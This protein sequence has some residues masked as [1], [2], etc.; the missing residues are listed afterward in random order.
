MRTGLSRHASESLSV[1]MN[2]AGKGFARARDRAAFFPRKPPLHA[3]ETGNAAP[4][5][6]NVAE[7]RGFFERPQE[8][9]F[10]QDYVV[11]TARLELRAY[12]LWLS[13]RSLSEAL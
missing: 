2:S 7:N 3:A 6:A 5:R 12:Q 8:T 13:N 4:P 10:A 9:A 11:E 1:G